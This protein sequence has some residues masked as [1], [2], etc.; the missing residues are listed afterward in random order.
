[1][2]IDGKNTTFPRSAWAGDKKQDLRKAIDKSI[3][4]TGQSPKGPG[5]APPAVARYGV[6]MPAPEGC[7]DERKMQAELDDAKLPE[8]P[9]APNLGRSFKGQTIQDDLPVDGL[10]KEVYFNSFGSYYVKVTYP[11]RGNPTGE[12]KWYGPGQLPEGAMLDS[13]DPSPP[14][15]PRYG[16]PM[17]RPDIEIPTPSPRYGAPMPEDWK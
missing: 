11:G 17:P 2:A 15:A 6:V 10:K 8:L 16:M 1:M 13:C 9:K 14:P 3:E 12:P 5:R 4:S 7:L